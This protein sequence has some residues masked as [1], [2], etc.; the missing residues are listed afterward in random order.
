MSYFIS[1]F[2]FVPRVEL[3][4]DCYYHRPELWDDALVALLPALREDPESILLQQLH[5]YLQGKITNKVQGSVYSSADAFSAFVTS[6]GN[7]G[8]YNAVCSYLADSYTK[9]IEKK[10]RSSPC[11]ELSNDCS[12]VISI[13]DIG[14]GAGHALVPALGSFLG[15]C[16]SRNFKVQIDLTLIEPFHAMLQEAVRELDQVVE[17]FQGYHTV[18]YE[19]Y[20]MTFQNFCKVFCTT[21]A[22]TTLKKWDVVQA[23]FSFQYVPVEIRTECV[24][25]IRN[26]SK[27]FILVEFDTPDLVF[28]APQT[29]QYL[30]QRNLIGLSE[31]TEN[32][33]L[34]AQGFLIPVLISN[35]VAK[36]SKT[37]TTATET[38]T[39]SWER[40]LFEVYFPERD[41]ENEKGNFVQF[42][43]DYWWAKC[44]V[45]SFQSPLDY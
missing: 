38:S 24:S 15:R 5:T 35:F 28:C 12:Y 26:R 25:W 27:Q 8:L 43:F 17:E 36:D 32:R 21:E 7:V 37:T 14:T 33:E 3:Y 18:R 30:F 13:L 41:W 10:R 11:T 34:V 4:L 39:A 40:L 19:T 45:V 20:E 9:C 31:Y 16:R 23:S 44:N 29:C 6:G 22:T 42:L 1:V 2:Y